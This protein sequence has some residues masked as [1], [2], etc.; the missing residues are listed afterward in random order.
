[1]MKKAVDVRHEPFGH[2][3]DILKKEPLV[4]TNL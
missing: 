2:P 1:M 4:A 3:V